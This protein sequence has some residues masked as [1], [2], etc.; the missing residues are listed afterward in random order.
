MLDVRVGLA[1]RS[2]AQHR[3]QAWNAL[4]EITAARHMVRM[5]VGVD[6]VNEINSELLGQL[7]VAL[8]A[9]EHWI[10]QYSLLCH[11]VSQQVSISKGD[12]VK[13]LQKFKTCGNRNKKESL[14]KY[15]KQLGIFLDFGG[16]S[17]H[18]RC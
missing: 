14:I 6:R 1:S 16:N 15:A 2:C 18:E 8:N 3:F 11:R 12:V 5:N 7:H 9:L 17:A 10:N 13:E 4:P